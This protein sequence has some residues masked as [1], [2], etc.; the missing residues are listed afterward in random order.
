MIEVR[1]YYLPP[2]AL[3]P[4]SPKPLLHYT[5]VPR[6]K[7]SQIYDLFKRNGWQVQWIYRYGPTQRS[8]Y[9]SGSHEC[10]VVLS[11]TA[12]IRF[13]VG[14]TSLDMDENTTGSARE[15]GG[16][17][18]EARA[19]DIFLLP[20]GTA[21]KTYNT[22]PQ[23]DFTL[24]SPGD[25]H[26]IPAEDA[27]IVL[28]DVQLSGFTMMGAYPE[29]SGYWD[30]MKGGENAGEYEKVWSVEMPESDPVLGKSEMGILGQ[31]SPKALARVSRL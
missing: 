29:G 5:G 28:D 10:M 15:E 12:T 11:G 25:G 2:T 7:P 22:K 21:H 23:A 16:I 20:A 14:D 13:G 26:S 27:R 30:S 3:M 24:L 6:G 18:V 9:H 1:K 19:G 17:E 31:W 4:N 8:H